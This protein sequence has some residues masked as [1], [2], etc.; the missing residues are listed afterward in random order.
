VEEDGQGVLLS[1]LSG[2]EFSPLFGALRPARRI[3][4]ASDLDGPFLAAIPICLLAARVSATL[5]RCR[6]T[7]HDFPRYRI[8][9]GL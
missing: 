8:G 5:A 7:I 9:I 4:P 2:V 3:K 1:E 6:Q